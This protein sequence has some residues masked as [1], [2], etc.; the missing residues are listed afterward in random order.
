MITIGIIGNGFLGKATSILASSEVQYKVYDINPEF[1]VPKY[2]TLDYLSDCNMIFIC[3]PTPMNLDGSCN[4]SIVDDVIQSIRKAISNPPSIIVRSTVPVGYCKSRGVHFMPEFLTEANW[5]HDFVNTERWILGIN[6]PEFH[7]KLK[8]DL[9]TIF[10]KA[11]NEQKIKSSLI[12]WISSCEAEATKYFRNCFLATKVSF[13]NEFKQFCDKLDVNYSNVIEG[14]IIDERIGKSHT[15]VPGPDGL[16]GY[17]GHCLVKDINSLRV[18]MR[19]VGCNPVLCDASITR[20][21]LLDRPNRDWYSDKYKGRV[22][23]ERPN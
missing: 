1:C 21:E 17:S 14:V 3:V 19:K 15:S 22:F 7:S 10:T 4:T 20:N 6:I 12:T 16:S 23:F 9:Q 13:C 11:S 2:C 8:N 5:K 18:Q